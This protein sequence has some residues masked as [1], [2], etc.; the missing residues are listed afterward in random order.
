MYIA[1][2]TNEYNNTLSRN[3]N[4]TNKNNNFEIIIPLFTKIPC[5]IL[6]MCLMSLI[7]YTLVKLLFNNN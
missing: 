7:V 1:N 5:G 4:C 3:K 2:I 6:L